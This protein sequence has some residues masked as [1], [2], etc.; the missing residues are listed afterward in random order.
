LAELVDG[1]FLDVR[2]KPELACHA[3]EFA[4]LCPVRLQVRLVR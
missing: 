2:G 4:D 3:R 1:N